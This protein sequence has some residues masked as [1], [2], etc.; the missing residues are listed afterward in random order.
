VVGATLLR[1]TWLRGGHAVGGSSRSQR[2]RG[3]TPAARPDSMTSRRC[4]PVRAHCVPKA[5]LHDGCSRTHLALA[6]VPPSLTRFTDLS[7]GR[8]LRSPR[9]AAFTA[10]TRGGRLQQ[11]RDGI[12]GRDRPAWRRPRGISTHDEELPAATAIRSV[13]MR[14]SE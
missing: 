12:P 7:S 5:L 6:R 13:A 14:L 1:V 10:A 8:S 11:S 2:C 9:W 4:V 3:V